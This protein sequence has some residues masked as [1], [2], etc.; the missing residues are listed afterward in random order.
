MIKT[1]ITK[2]TTNNYQNKPPQKHPEYDQTIYSCVDYLNDKMVF[3][4]VTGVKD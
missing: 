2:I 4:I 1:I 3:F